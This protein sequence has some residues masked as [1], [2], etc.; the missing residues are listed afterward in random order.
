MNKRPRRSRKFEQA[1]NQKAT[2]LLSGRLDELRPTQRV[3]FSKVAPARARG[4]ELRSSF[5][6]GRGHFS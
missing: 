2:G 6:P 1:W 5:H 4:A 3:K